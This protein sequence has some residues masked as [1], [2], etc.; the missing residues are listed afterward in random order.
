MVEITLDLRRI[1]EIKLERDDLDNVRF[2]VEGR[3]DDDEKV[4]EVLQAGQIKPVSLT[5]ET[6][7]E[8]LNS[9]LDEDN[10]LQK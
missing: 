9:N 7:S 3:I 8:E 5:V 1:P 4:S 2:S 6:E 10:D